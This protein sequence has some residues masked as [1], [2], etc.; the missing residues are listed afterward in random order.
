MNKHSV[1][2][3]LQQFANQSLGK[4][5]VKKIKGGN[6]DNKDDIVIADIIII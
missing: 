1:E 3:K 2:S 4:S 5:E 6:G